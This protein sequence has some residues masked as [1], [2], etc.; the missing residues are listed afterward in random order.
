M[1]NVLSQCHEYG[2]INVIN[3][4]ITIALIQMIIA[5][6]TDEFIGCLTSTF[7]NYIQY[8]SDINK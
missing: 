6:K 1:R 3:H 4:D 2:K 5:S 8:T 7:S